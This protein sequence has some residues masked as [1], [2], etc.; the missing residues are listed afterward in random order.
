M[1][2]QFP[3]YHPTKVI[4]IDD[5][6]SFL[7]SLSRHIDKEILFKC[8]ADVSEAL[9]DINT[10]HHPGIYETCR[11]IPTDEAGSL[12]T[13]LVP[14][15]FSNLKEEALNAY[16]FHETSVVIVDYLMPSINGLELCSRIQRPEIRKILLTGVFDTSDAINALNDGVI[17]GYLNKNDTNLSEKL[18]NIIQKQ[19]QAYFREVSKRFYCS[20][21]VIPDFMF[22]DAFADYFSEICRDNNIKEYYLTT[23]SNGFVLFGENKHDYYRLLV[24]STEDIRAQWEIAESQYA[25]AELIKKLAV[26]D[27]IPDFWKTSG[28]YDPAYA[29]NWQNFVFVPGKIIQGTRQTYYCHLQYRPPAYKNFSNSM[30]DLNTSRQEMINNGTLTTGIPLKGFESNGAYLKR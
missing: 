25:P 23:E 11:G 16:R 15:D 14:W 9:A 5:D 10:L 1:I 26:A 22:E 24:Y 8:Y 18:N 27:V 4:L 7:D 17:C 20:G 3:Y 29:S 13:Q 19:Q 28:T 30:T 6:I 2:D 12:S 21:A